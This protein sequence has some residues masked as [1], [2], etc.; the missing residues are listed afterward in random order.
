LDPIP[1]LEEKEILIRLIEGDSNAF[2]K[3]Y[4]RYVERV[5]YF[6]LRYLTCAADAEEIVQEVFTKIWES[7]KNINTDLSFS[8]YLL[9]TAKNTIF[10]DYRKKVNHQ[11]YC[12]YIIT[13]LQKS[14]QNVEDEII[15][16]DLMEILN[17]TLSGLPP[18]RQEIF[19]LSRFQGMAYRDISKKLSISEKTIETHMR[20]AIRDI[21]LGL[22]PILDKIVT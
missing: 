7:R 3:I 18:K 13:Y 4:Y 17:K 16:N 10:N 14:I 9:T 11:A 15:Y 22:A 2:E 5:Y 19:R 1:Q 12:E 6:S 21:K 20:L 8:G